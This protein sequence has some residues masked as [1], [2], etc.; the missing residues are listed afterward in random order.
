M[1][2]RKAGRLGGIAFCAL[3]F[4]VQTALACE[5]MLQLPHHD[6]SA[7]QRADCSYAHAEGSS[8]DFSGGPAVNIG[9]GRVAQKLTFDHHGCWVDERLFVANCAAGEAAIFDG[10]EDVTTDIRIEGAS[11]TKIGWIQPPHGPIA[12]TPVVEIEQLLALAEI[13]DIPTKRL[14][15]WSFGE[16]RNEVELSCACRLFYPDTPGARQ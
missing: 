1:I 10:I 12:L 2:G 15:R 5:P 13:S 4:G 3:V 14:A 16:G 8:G 11:Y 7:L 9:D 6:Q